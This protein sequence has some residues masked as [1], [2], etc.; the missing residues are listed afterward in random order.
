MFII[1]QQFRRCKSLEKIYKCFFTK[2]STLVELRSILENSDSLDKQDFFFFYSLL[3][4]HL[5][6]TDLIKNLPPFRWGSPYT[7]EDF[8]PLSAYDTFHE[9]HRIPEL[10]VERKFRAYFAGGKVG[11][12]GERKREGM[13]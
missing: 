6:P 7:K 10:Q 13:K 4:P 12:G 9:K 3:I 5:F 2:I 8:L 11:R 1:F